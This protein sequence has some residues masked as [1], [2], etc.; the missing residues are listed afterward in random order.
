MITWALRGMGLHDE[1]RMAPGTR[2]SFRPK[3]AGLVA[4]LAYRRGSG[5]TSIGRADHSS[6]GTPAFMGGR[7]MK[8]AEGENTKGESTP[9][10]GVPRG[11]LWLACIALI[12]IAGWQVLHGVFV[13]SVSGPGG[14]EITFYP[15]HDD[16]AATQSQRNTIDQ[17]GGEGNRAEIHG[18][19]NRIVQ[20]GAHNTATIGGLPPDD[21]ADDG[22]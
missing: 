3:P 2:P 1:K 19:D 9:A 7:D 21:K 10:F 17:D 16:P 12:G 4:M 18:A 6:P 20:S 11:L 5:P 14:S 13:K 22:H 8:K 15:E